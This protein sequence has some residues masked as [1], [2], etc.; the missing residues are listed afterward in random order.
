M[1]KLKGKRAYQEQDSKSFFEAVKMNDIIKVLRFLKNNPDLVDDID[2]MQR[3]PMHWATQRG[4]EKMLEILIDYGGDVF[5]KDAFERT[6]R[7]I[8]DKKELK[9]II[10]L[11]R[12]V[13]S[14]KYIRSTEKYQNL[15]Y[16]KS[17]LPH[18]R[19][20]EFNKFLGNPSTI[21]EELNFLYQ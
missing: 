12:K 13:E 19:I 18:S 11:L 14:A 5:L 3:S 4:F 17:L 15:L 9:D 1:A 8:A 6:A 10:K 20:D 7:D 16:V 2:R 21:N